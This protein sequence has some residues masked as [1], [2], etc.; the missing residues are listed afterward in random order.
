MFSAK[1]VIKYVDREET[2]WFHSHGVLLDY[3]GELVLAHD[4]VVSFTVYPNA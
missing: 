3:L 2:L 1:L 4:D